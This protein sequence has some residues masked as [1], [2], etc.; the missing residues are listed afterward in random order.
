MSKKHAELKFKIGDVVCIKKGVVPAE[1]KKMEGKKGRII[2]FHDKGK[3]IELEWDSDYLKSLTEFDLKKMNKED[4]VPYYLFIPAKDIEAA[5][6][7]DTLE[8][9]EFVQDLIEKKILRVEKRKEDKNDFR[10]STEKWLR[11]FYHSLYFR[12]LNYTGQESLFFIV[13]CFAEFMYNYHEQLPKDWDAVALN[14]VCLNWIPRKVSADAQTFKDFGNVL[15]QFFRFLED[16]GYLKATKLQEEIK[17]IDK[18]IYKASQ[19]KENWGMA[20][21]FGLQAMESGIDITNPK[22]LQK[23][24]DTYND[25]IEKALIGDKKS[26]KERQKKSNDK[27]TIYQLKI[28]IEGSKPPIWRRIHVKGKD[29]LSDLHDIIQ[30]IMGWENEHLH[31]F[32]IDGEYY[33]DPDMMEEAE[34]ESKYTLNSFGFGEKDKFIYEYD[35]GDSWTHKIEVEKMLQPESGK[36]YPVCIAGKLA[37]PPEDC[38]GI[39]GYYNFLEVVK[40]PKHPEHEDMK[41]WLGDDFDPDYFDISEINEQLS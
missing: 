37:A 19:K 32:E 9:V 13:D 17:K 12:E 8:E 33:S 23:F 34:S 7:E 39:W 3:V 18:D 38:G 25:N 31:Q 16:K 26:K 20:K 41:E 14:D 11:R 30:I 10:T 35:F 2:N 5:E 36:K 22:E 21:I 1:K 28:T 15:F 6:P 4:E 29:K 27:N 24:V 40:N